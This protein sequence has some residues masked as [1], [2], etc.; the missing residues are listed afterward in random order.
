MQLAREYLLFQYEQARAWAMEQLTRTEIIREYVQIGE[1]ERTTPELIASVSRE[2]GVNPL[3]TEAIIEQESGG[4]ADA[5]R[6]EPHVFARLKTGSED[7]RRMLASSH[8]LLQVMGHH[9]ANT[10]GLKSWSELYKRSQNIRCGLTILKH[11]LHQHRS[12]MKPGQRLRLALRSYNGSGEKAEQYA[13]SVMA[14]IADK[15]LTT[16]GLGEGI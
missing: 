11:A 1:D 5:I 2:M 13:D 14:R 10:C 3:I 6:F 8:G 12:V 15:L 9:A 7:Q 4:K 16:R